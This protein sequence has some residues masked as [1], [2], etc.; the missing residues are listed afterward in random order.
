MRN[1]KNLQMKINSHSFKKMF[2]TFNFQVNGP[3]FVQ[4][5]FIM[6]SRQSMLASKKKSACCLYSMNKK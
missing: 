4:R 6:I 1:D 2:I 3:F 5:Q